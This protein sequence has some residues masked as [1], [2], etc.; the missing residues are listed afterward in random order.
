MTELKAAVTL[1]VDVEQIQRLLPHRYPFLL[2]DRVIEIEPGKCITAKSLVTASIREPGEYS[3]GSP[4]Q[5]NRLWR[6]N[7]ARM[8]HLDEYARRLAA[9]EKDKGQ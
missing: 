1:P 4:L 9:L 5:E 8:K 3:S 7:A 2:V 6:R